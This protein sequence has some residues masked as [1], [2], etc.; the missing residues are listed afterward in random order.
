MS[1]G[2]SL[3]STIYHRFSTPTLLDMKK[4]KVSVEFTPYTCSDSEFALED[5]STHRRMGKA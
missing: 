3:L 4:A 2:G 1:S 5:N